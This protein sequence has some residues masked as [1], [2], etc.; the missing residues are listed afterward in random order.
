MRAYLSSGP[1]TIASREW[2]DAAKAPG[3]EIAR[4]RAVRVRTA[5]GGPADIVDIR[6]PLW[7]DME[8][9]VLKSG[10]VLLPY[11][12]VHNEE[13]LH[14]F[15][16]LDVDPE[17]RQRPR[18]E[19]RWVSTVQIPGNLLAE[20]MHFVTAG[21]FTLDP[22]VHQFGVQEAVAFQVVESPDEGSARGD[23][24]G[25]LYGVV[26]PRLKWTTPLSPAARMIELIISPFSLMEDQ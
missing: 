18:P 21:L 3:G 8:Y 7:I 19:G 17:W 26:R 2:S 24:T 23:W 13:A 9:D 14:I 1:S 5:D 22:R 10:Y 25:E 4:L 11:H 15:S 6:N 20:G 16:T 12:D